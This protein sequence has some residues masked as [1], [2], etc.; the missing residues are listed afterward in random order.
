METG[1]DIHLEVGICEAMHVAEETFHS[2]SLALLQRVLN[3][4]YS[5]EHIRCN[6]TFAFLLLLLHFL[7]LQKLCFG[8]HFGFS[9]ICGLHL[10]SKDFDSSFTERFSSLFVYGLT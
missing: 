5:Q 4:D 9:L 8:F 6:L 3:V 1:V 2:G 7:S 10:L